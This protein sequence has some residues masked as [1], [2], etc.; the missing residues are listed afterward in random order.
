MCASLPLFCMWDAS[1]AWLDEWYRSMLGIQTHKPLAAEAERAELSHHA[2]RLA[3]D[4]LFFEIQ[5]FSDFSK[6]IQCV[7]Q[8]FY[9]IH[10]ITLLKSEKF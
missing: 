5:N 8:R 3:P 6:V 9:D 1:T 4:Q 2:T 7:Y 10:W